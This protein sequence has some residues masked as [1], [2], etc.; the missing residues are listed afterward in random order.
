LG[1]VLENPSSNFL[2]NCNFFLAPIDYGFVISAQQCA[3]MVT[4]KGGFRRIHGHPGS[5]RGWFSARM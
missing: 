3:K 2:H 4:Q 5:I 1:N